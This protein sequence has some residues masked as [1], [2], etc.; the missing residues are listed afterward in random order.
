MGITVQKK[1]PCRYEFYFGMTMCG[2]LLET[3]KLFLFGFLQN[4]NYVVNYVVI[5]IVK[6]LQLVSCITN[7]RHRKKLQSSFKV[8]TLFCDKKPSST[9]RHLY[10]VEGQ[11]HFD[12]TISP[13]TI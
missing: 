5:T 2:L 12:G 9:D 3:G 10:W 4:S 11:Y 1:N 7:H 6:D 13:S 8:L